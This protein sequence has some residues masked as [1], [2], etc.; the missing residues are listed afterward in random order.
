MISFS[1]KTE[2]IELYKLLKASGLID[3]GGMAKNVIM[4][5]LVTVDGV[6][7]TRKG[8]KIR[9]GQVVSFNGE[10]VKVV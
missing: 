7:E 9:P 8:C 2:Y 10:S 5:E 4:D 1:C 6:V 3:T